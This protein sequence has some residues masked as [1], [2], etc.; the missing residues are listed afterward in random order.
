MSTNKRLLYEME[1]LKTREE[2]TSNTTNALIHLFI[3]VFIYKYI[4]AVFSSRRDM[5]KK[6]YKEKITKCTDEGVF[7]R[8]TRTR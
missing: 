4:H 1:I 3:H 8:F 2:N 7:I 6:Y 5:D